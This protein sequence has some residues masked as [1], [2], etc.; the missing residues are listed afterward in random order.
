MKRDRSKPLSAADL[1]SRLN[2][3]PQFVR[4]N[5]ERET[6]RHAL[7]A[8]LREEEQPLIAELRSVGLRVDSIWEL[9]NFKGAYPKAIPILIRHLQLPYHPKV[10]EGIARALT[11]KEARGVATMCIIAEL[12]R[13]KSPLEAEYRWAL[14]NALSVVGGQETC[15]EIEA[16]MRDEALKENKSILQ[17]AL[18]ECSKR[19]TPNC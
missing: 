2:G 4:R 8:Q 10:R 6:R 17:Q 18:K 15:A 5:Q 14:A 12:R 13:S 11:V 1:I 16:L 9:V 19:A 3:D 7:E